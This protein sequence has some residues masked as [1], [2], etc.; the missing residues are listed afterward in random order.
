MT[1]F[2]VQLIKLVGRCLTSGISYRRD[3]QILN[4]LFLSF[5]IRRLLSLDWGTVIFDLIITFNDF[6]WINL[7]ILAIRIKFLYNL[8]Y[9]VWWRLVHFIGFNFNI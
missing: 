6:F 8:F 1:L 7:A 5:F 4:L 2:Q 9:I 3:L